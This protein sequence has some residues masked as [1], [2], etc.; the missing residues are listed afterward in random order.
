M[1]RTTPTN[2]LAKEFQK[3]VQFLYGVL[4]A[5][6]T[7]NTVF[8]DINYIS[9]KW[10]MVVLARSM[11]LCSSF[12]GHM[13]SPTHHAIGYQISC[14]GSLHEFLIYKCQFVIIVFD[15]L[16]HQKF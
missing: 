6:K 13:C 16:D 3:S 5:K 11:C 15:K 14:Y 8:F 9:R 1:R 10:R 12:R 2:F 4:G 7:P